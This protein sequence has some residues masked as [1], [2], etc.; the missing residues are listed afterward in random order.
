MRDVTHYF[1]VFGWANRPEFRFLDLFIPWIF[2]VAVFGFLAAWLIMAALERT[3]LSR[4]IWHLPLFFLALV[5][6]L[7]SIIGFVCF[8]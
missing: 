4:H 2:A 3:G 1:S 7:S 8:P 6:L 5:I